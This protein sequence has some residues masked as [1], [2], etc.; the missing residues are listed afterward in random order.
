MNVLVPDCSS[1]TVTFRGVEESLLHQL[2]AFYLPDLPP[3]QA[4][5]I[6]R[7]YDCWSDTETLLPPCARRRRTPRRT[8]GGQR[9]YVLRSRSGRRLHGV[10]V[11]DI[12]DEQLADLSRCNA[13]LQDAAA[14]EDGPLHKALAE[15]GPGAGEALVRLDRTLALLRLRPPGALF[16]ALPRDETDGPVPVTL[17]TS[18]EAAYW[19]YYGQLAGLTGGDATHCPCR[20]P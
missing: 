8:P 12:P 16:D 14:A 18:Q 9:G 17:D 2:C 13:V 10:Y 6:Q 7:G 3:E 11:V 15:L 4:G 1:F 5:A 19:N 20:T